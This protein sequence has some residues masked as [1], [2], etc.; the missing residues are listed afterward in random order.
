VGLDPCLD[1]AFAPRLVLGLR[2][3]EL[4]MNRPYAL[5]LLAR[6]ANGLAV[7]TLS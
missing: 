3:A 1:V 5:P 7:M 6:V 2:A 4:D